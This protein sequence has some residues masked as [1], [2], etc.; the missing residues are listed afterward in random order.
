MYTVI[1]GYLIRNE[2]VKI[3]PSKFNK[4]AVK[5]GLDKQNKDQIQDL[6]N[7]IQEDEELTKV[8][9]SAAKGELS[10]ED[11]S[12]VGND[13]EKPLSEPKAIEQTLAT[14]VKEN[15]VTKAQMREFR[16]IQREEAHL[17][18]ILDNFYQKELTEVMRH[19]PKELKKGNT[20][21]VVDDKL[22]KRKLALFPADWHIGAMVNVHNGNKYNYDIFKNRLD[23]YINDVLD[24]IDLFKPHKLGV[25][26]LGDLIEHINMRDVDQPFDAE[27][28]ASKQIALALDSI[29]YLIKRLEVA[30]LPIELGLISGN[31]DRVA[32]DKKKNIH[33]DTFVYVILHSL[34]RIKES[35]G[36]SNVSIIDNRDDIYKL[37]FKIFDKHILCVHGDKLPSQR[38]KISPYVKDTPIDYLFYGHFHSLEIAQEDYAKFR[39]MMPSIMGY[40]N[41]SEDLV[42][43][44]T[45]ASQA[46]VLFEEGKSPLIIPSFFNK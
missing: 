35:G 42:L 38:K 11:L 46:M 19:L 31:H 22:P 1:I 40:N 33:G 17:Q 16:K 3:Q 28:R 20:L 9:E 44:S 2:G 32:S 25:Y 12:E 24:R 21:R 6:V 15:E 8:Y 18:V 10:I 37:N 27:F 7:S 34:L 5:L 29:L 4:L 36:L 43:P 26:H 13:E 41:Y 30:G 45:Y 14:Y 23:E 39:F